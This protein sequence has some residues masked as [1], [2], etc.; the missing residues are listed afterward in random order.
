MKTVKY[1]LAFFFVF[2]A[3][4]MCG[5]SHSAKTSAEKTISKD[6]DLLKNLDSDT[7][8]KYISYQELFPDSENNAELSDDIKE[9]FSLFF[10]N[11]DEND[12]AADLADAVPW[13]HKILAVAEKAAEF[14]RTRKNES[15]KMSRFWIEFHINRT[16]ERFAGAD[17]DNFF[18]AEIYNAHAVL[19]FTDSYGK[20]Y[21]KM[22]LQLT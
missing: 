20:T 14:H 21:A 16:A 13:D 17:I 12:I 22:L 15:G 8:M 9:V 19:L 4:F 11:F 5:C 18:L 3:V 7:T 10:R 1:L 6:L 2:L